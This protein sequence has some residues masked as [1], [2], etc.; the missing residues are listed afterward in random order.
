MFSC[1]SVRMKPDMEKIDLIIE[2]ED[3]GTFEMPKIY[4]DGFSDVSDEEPM[5]DWSGDSIFVKRGTHVVKYT[6]LSM[7]DV[8]L[9]GEKGEPIWVN[10]QAASIEG[11]VAD[12]VTDFAPT[13]EF[14]IEEYDLEK[15]EKRSYKVV[16]ERTSAIDASDRRELAQ[17]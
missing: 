7:C 1:G 14:R 12:E 15:A 2:D 10:G 5:F 6:E 8:L 3:M 16:L 9:H 11:V 4:Y 17:L 13:N